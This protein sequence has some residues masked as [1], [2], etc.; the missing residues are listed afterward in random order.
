MRA[1]RLAFVLASS[2][3]SAA[4]SPSSPMHAVDAD[5]AVCTE[6]RAAWGTDPSSCERAT[7]RAIRGVGQV[8]LWHASTQGAQ[9]W[10]IAVHVGSE[11][12]VSPAIAVPSDDCGAGHCN[13][14][15]VV[16]VV[17][18][19]HPGGRPA[20]AVE[21]RIEE[22]WTESESHRTYRSG[23]RTV[24]LVCGDTAR[25]GRRCATF[26]DGDASCTTKLADD[27]TI[28]RTCS[29]RVDLE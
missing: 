26:D 13:E 18:A 23:R 1:T 12:W 10:A 3:A 29:E 14:V 22:R 8:D 20:V 25:D 27:G 7:S 15:T 17:R 16:P 9:T 11:R 2:A 24:L 28:T 5:A 21:L 6:L 19:L 4:A